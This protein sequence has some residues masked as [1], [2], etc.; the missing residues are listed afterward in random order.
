[1]NIA[2]LSDIHGNHVAF[3]SCMNYLESREIDAFIFLGDYVGEFPRTEI[4]M[5]LIYELQRKYPCYIIRGNK[6]EYQLGG[7]GEDKPEWDAYPS[8]IGM[9]RYAAKHTR[10]KDLKYFAGLPITMRVEFPDLPP[11]RIC[12]GSPRNIKEDIRPEYDVNQEIFA[13]IEETYVVSGHTHRVT[14]MAEYG[15]IVWNPGSVGLSLNG[16]AKAQ[17]M[18]LHGEDRRWEPEFLEI[19]YDTDKVI[20]EM[21]EENLYELAPYWTKITESLVRGGAVSHGKVLARAMELCRQETGVCDWP[22][23]PEKYWKK[24]CEELL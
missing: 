11:L 4:T 22:K 21:W 20:C 8:T 18:I 17:F 23:I 5:E 10:K 15:K 19:E 12:H 2:V 7:L 1:M 3:E 14:D 16:S 9:I 6:E 13:E 24:A